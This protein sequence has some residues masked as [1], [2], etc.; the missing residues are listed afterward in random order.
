MKRA[1]CVYRRYGAKLGTA[2]SLV[3]ALTAPTGGVALAQNVNVQVTR[4][5]GGGGSSGM[6]SRRSVEKYAEVLGLTADQKESVLTMHSGYAAAFGEKQKAMRDAIDEVRRS[7]DDSGDHSVFME[8]MPKIQ[9]DF[10]D[11]TAKLEKDFLSDFKAVLTTP[12]QEERWPKVEKA[13]RRE[14]GLRQG[15]I[16]GEGVDLI[17]VVDGLRLEPEA[18]KP[19]TPVLDDYESELDRLLKDREAK[20]SDAP[21]WE[22]GKPIDLEAM[23]KQMK[24]SRDSGVKAR[25]INQNNARKVEGLLPE[26]KRDAFKQAF[27]NACFPKVFRESR[28][29]K[30]MDAASKFSDLDASQREQLSQLRTSYEHDLPGLNSA[31]ANAIES[32][33]NKGELGA[34][35][36]GPGGSMMLSMNDEP[37]DL[38]NARKARRELDEKTG[39]KL[40]SILR[41]DQKDKLPK[42]FEGDDEGP[43]PGQMM[44]IRRGE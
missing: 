4:S 9:K 26:N 35:V 17:A 1:S 43:G 24:E 8:R 39:S 3:L 11:G 19:L 29:S 36:G 13:R 14:V 33:D 40:R 23:Q 38:K 10:K 6:I 5:L 28:V 2:A 15:S 42:Q 44:M 31:W 16:S 37:E 34:A 12:A 27:R 41:P 30:E 25:E 7:A 32:A 20:A 21:A 18:A 22:P